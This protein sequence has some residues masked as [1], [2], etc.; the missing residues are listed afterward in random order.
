MFT[1]EQLQKKKKDGKQGLWVLAKAVNYTA[2]Y[3]KAT[4]K[5]LIEFILEAQVQERNEI[6][7]NELG[8]V[9]NPRVD[10]EAQE[11]VREERMPP[12]A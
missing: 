2:P 8:D 7:M 12:R 10:P 3:R 4:R 5:D 9:L 11:V 1:R 6:K